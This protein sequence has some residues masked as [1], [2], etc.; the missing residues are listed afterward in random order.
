MPNPVL[1]E[2]AIA[3]A[4][5]GWAAPKPPSPGGATWAP[6]SGPFTGADPITDGPVSEWRGGMTVRG[7]INRTS[8]LLVLLVASAAVGWS[9]T[10]VTTQIVG[11]VETQVAE[12][13]AIAM[14]GILIGFGIS[15][16]MYFRPMWAKYLAPT[17]ALAFGFAVG[18][19]SKGY[20][21]F[22]NG[23]V[24][25]A[26][27]ATIAVTAVMLVLYRTNII[28]VTNRFRKAVIFAT[29]GIMLMYGVSLIFTLFGASVGFINSPSAFGIGLSVVICIVASLNLALDFDFIEKGA[30]AGLAK[31]YEWFAA[32]GLLVT[33]VWL[34]LE[35]LRLFAKLNSR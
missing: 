27:A 20:E 11:G 5:A 30:R 15:I 17:Y 2:K 16:G 10:P 13:P 31:D 1:N 24:L 19:I 33:L 4:R 28:K 29:L 14:L 18:C 7:V 9:A 3:E 34:Y 26:A 12:F 23:I 25:Q 6:P 8:V 21:T 32:F 22:Q 35:L